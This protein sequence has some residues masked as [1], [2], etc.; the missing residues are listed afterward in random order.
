MTTQI[1]PALLNPAGSTAGQVLVSTGPL[2]PPGWS[3]SPVTLGGNNAWTGTNT[4]SLPA[5]LALGSTAPGLLGSAVNTFTATGTTQAT[6]AQITTDY[7]TV[8]TATAGQ[9]IIAASA[10]GG[11]NCTITNKTAVSIVL[12]PAVGQSFD[13]LATNAG[14][15]M[16]PNSLVELFGISS[17]QWNTSL[18]AIINGSMILGTV[19]LATSST[20]AGTVTAAAQ[21]NITSVGT[22]TALTVTGAVAAG[23]FSGASSALTGVSSF[24]NATATGTGLYLQSGTGKITSPQSGQTY[25]VGGTTP[26]TDATLTLYGSTN[27]NANLATLDAASIRFRTAGS[28]EYARFAPTTNNLLLGT[29]TD[30]GI[31]KLQVAGNITGQYVMASTALKSAGAVIAPQSLTNRGGGL[32]VAVATDLIVASTTPHGVA[33]DSNGYWAYVANAGNATVG[34]FSINQSTGVLTSIATAIA[35][36]TGPFSITVDPTN[37]FAYTANATAA[38]VSQYSINQS[39]GALTS[40]GADIATGASPRVIVVDPSGRF[41]YTVNYSGSTISMFSINQTTGAL[42]SITTD[43]SSGQLNP[44]TIAIEPTGRF[45]Y[46]G[47]ATSSQIAI[48]SINQTTGALTA[49]GSTPTA[50]SGGL[51]IDPAG[52][53]LYSFVAAGTLYYYSINQATGALTLVG[54]LVTTITPNGLAIDPT[55]RYLYALN[56]TNS[57][58][59]TYILNPTNGNVVAIG[60]TVSTGNSPYKIAIDPTGRFAYTANYGNN[61]V[62]QYSIQNLSSGSHVV[63]GSITAST[64]SAFNGVNVG[65]GG[66]AIAGNTSVGYGALRVN[67]TGTHNAGGG[68]A[69]LYSNTTGVNNTS[70]GYQGLYNNVSGGNNTAFGQNALFNNS[71]GSSNVAIG[72]NALFSTTTSIATLGTPTG[73][74]GYTNGTY[75]N[76]PLTYVS[77]SIGQSYPTATIV[78]AG[79]VVSTVTLTTFGGGFYDTTTVFSAAAANIGGTGTGFTVQTATLATANNNTAVGYNAGYNSNASNNTFV[80]YSAGYTNAT[81]N[82]N[83]GLGVNALYSLTTGV[84]NTGVGV[85]ALQNATTSTANT[86]I[87][88]SAGQGTTTGTGNTLL[89]YQTGYTATPANANVSGSNNTWVGYNAGPGTTTQLSNSTAIGANAVN[90]AS[91]QVVLG[92]PAVTS[93]VTTGAV[94][95]PRIIGTS[96]TPT[97]VAGAGAGTSPTI[98]VV[99]TDLGFRL[100]LTTGTSPTASAVIAT[101]TF[102]SAFSAVPHVGFSPASAAAGQASGASG[103]W[104]STTTTTWVLNSNT[105]ALTAS[106]SYIWEVH[107]LQ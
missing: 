68:Y 9:G 93:V 24:A 67:S 69:S 19:P 95:L 82:N 13:G 76:V 80:G 14:I 85:N 97:V 72:S 89:G 54:S 1:S 91:N 56:L 78:V 7:V 74:S 57:T 31:S 88:F 55:G 71:S 63:A 18:N 38:T 30:D 17:T 23:S 37:R 41:A 51:I 39:T 44:L 102:S 107:T 15:T 22:L 106:T 70:F 87:G 73:G 60:G 2:T 59:N 20:T 65:M 5:T 99:G 75:T 49:A 48:F 86:A 46:V 42:T 43:I 52:K 11:K 32:P 33:I 21:P 58:I 84:Y 29:T 64:D 100:T 79:G 81:G 98:S 50:G 4:F 101:V 66:G 16:Q 25:I 8:T 94:S 61:G 40:I 6:A 36:G 45:L 62:G 47:T 10:A 28:T 92:S 105:T 77:G 26:G 104:G 35:S 96:A 3:S 27:G 103:V 90:T 12:Y 34:Q 53:F 83:S